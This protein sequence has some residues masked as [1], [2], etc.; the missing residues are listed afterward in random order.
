VTPLTHITGLAPNGLAGIEVV[1]ATPGPST[2]FGP[3]GGTAILKASVAGGRVMVTTYRGVEQDT[4]PIEFKIARLDRPHEA[5]PSSVA[6]PAGGELQSS[7]ANTDFQVE[8]VLHIER[9]GDQRFIGGDWVGGRG[10]KQRIE[11]F[12]IRPLEPL[13]AQDIEYKAFGP[14]G[15]ETPWVTDARLC[16]SRGREMPLTGFSVR[17]VGAASDQFD[18]VYEGAFFESGATDP[19]RNGETCVASLQDDPLEAIAVRLIERPA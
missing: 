13:T 5:I 6:P 15:R 4:V 2:W 16:G 18:V 11:A 14:Q 19:K 3:E 9:V 8:I 17:L 10:H 12:S 1:A 7:G